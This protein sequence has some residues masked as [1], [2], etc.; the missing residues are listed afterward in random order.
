M[1]STFKAWSDMDEIVDRVKQV[2]VDRIYRILGNLDKMARDIEQSTVP[3]LRELVRR[4]GRGVLWRDALVFG[5]L[6][7]TG[8]GILLAGGLF[9]GEQKW[10]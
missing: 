9:Q 10:V 6:A 7:V 4:W 3:K 8:L 5:L 1:A 2:H